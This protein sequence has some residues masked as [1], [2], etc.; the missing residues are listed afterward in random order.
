MKKAQS[1]HVL[2]RFKKYEKPPPEY[3]SCLILK[4]SK[5]IGTEE[6]LSKKIATCLGPIDKPTPDRT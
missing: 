2:I 4:I 1:T 3:F 5:I 6:H